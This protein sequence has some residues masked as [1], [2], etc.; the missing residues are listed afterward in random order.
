MDCSDLVLIS[1]STLAPEETRLQLQHLSDRQC[2]P[3]GSIDCSQTP[4]AA[5]CAQIP[6]FPA[7]CHLPS[8][9]C[10]T[11]VHASDAD[12]DALEGLHRAA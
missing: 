7:L 5:V 8:G 10:S 1:H 12:F 11:G 6:A 2:Q 4:E 3:R 9:N